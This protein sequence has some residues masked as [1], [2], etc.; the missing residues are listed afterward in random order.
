MLGFQILSRVAADFGDSFIA[1]IEGMLED[2]HVLPGNGRP[3]NPPDQFFRF[4]AEHTAAD[5]FDATTIVFHH[6]PMNC[7]DE[8]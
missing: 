7:V 4:A 5:H 1:V 3:P 2:L 6:S 8:S